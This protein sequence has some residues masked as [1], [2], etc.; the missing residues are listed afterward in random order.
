MGLGLRGLVIFC[1]L[2]KIEIILLV[3]YKIKLRI[4]LPPKT[5]IG[6]MIMTTILMTEGKIQ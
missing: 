3:K 1:P 4:P 5:M 6:I 2:N